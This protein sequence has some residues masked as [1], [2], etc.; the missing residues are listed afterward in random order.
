MKSSSSNE[1]SKPL[2]FYQFLSICIIVVTLAVGKFW[3]L[4][5]SKV[6]QSDF[7]ELENKVVGQEEVVTQVRIS[8]GAILNELKN[9]KE[10]VQK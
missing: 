8:L 10:A 4:E 2:T 7:K 1:E 5:V 3:D 6:N 9:I